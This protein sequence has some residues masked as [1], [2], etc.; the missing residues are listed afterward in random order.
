MH[1]VYTEAF[2]MQSELVPVKKTTPTILR[3]A[4]GMLNFLQCRSAICFLEGIHGIIQTARHERGGIPLS[5]VFFF[6]YLSHRGQIQTPFTHRN[7][8]SA[9]KFCRGC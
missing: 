7:Q 2:R 9:G 4:D 6:H 8:R 5:G 1:A 3:H